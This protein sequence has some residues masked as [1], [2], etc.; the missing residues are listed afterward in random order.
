[1]TGESGDDR[2]GRIELHEAVEDLLGDGAPVR[3]GDP[4]G[5]EGD[6]IA[7]EDAAVRRALGGVSGL[8]AD[9]SDRCE[10]QQRRAYSHDGCARGRQAPPAQRLRPAQDAGA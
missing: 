8:R 7:T 1:M 3:I 6:G 9:R 4:G 10:D 2:E 5:I